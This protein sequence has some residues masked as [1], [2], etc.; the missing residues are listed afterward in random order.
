MSD[1]PETA[2]PQAPL[3][4]RC[5]ATPLKGAPL[6]A[7]GTPATAVARMAGSAALWGCKNWSRTWSFASGPSGAMAPVLPFVPSGRAEK[8]RA[9][10]GRG[11]RRMAALRALTRCGCSSG[12][13]FGAHSEFRSAVPCPSIPGCPQRSEGTR[14]VG[15]PFL[16][17]LSFGEA[18]ESRCAAGR[19]S[20]PATI[21]KDARAGNQ[22]SVEQGF[23]KLSPNGRCHPGRRCDSGQNQPPALSQ[24]AQTAIKSEVNQSAQP[25][26]S[27]ATRLLA[28]RRIDHF[29]EP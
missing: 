25:Q 16:C 10:G 8:R 26:V 4:S 23:D 1:T 14:Q 9:W 12:A 11:H 24:Q 2:H 15:S 20:R 6:V 19:T 28:P 22:T 3:A 21:P 5:F 18:K 13:P 17:L 7:G 27:T 29:V